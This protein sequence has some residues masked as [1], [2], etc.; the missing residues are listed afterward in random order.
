MTKSEKSGSEPSDFV[1]CSRFDYR[2][3]PA[4]RRLGEFRH[5]TASLYD[6]LAIGAEEDFRAEALGYRAD[7]LIFTRVAFSPT[8]FIRNEQHLD[9][10]GSGFLVLQHQYTGSELLLM[11]HGNIHIDAGNIYLRDWSFPFVSHASEMRLDSVVI[12]RHRLR[13]SVL[14]DAEHPVLSM[15]AVSPGGRMLA[16]IW[17]DL[18]SR[19]PGMPL[20]DAEVLCEAFLGFLDGLLGHGAQAKPNKTLRSMEQFLLVRLRQNV[21]VEDLCRHFHISRTQ[22]FRLFQPHGG[23]MAF[24]KR[25][26]LERCHAELLTADPSRTRVIDVAAS[27][28]FDDPSLFSRQFRSIFGQCPSAVLGKAHT[29]RLRP[30]ENKED[31]PLSPES[32]G[33][34]RK[35]LSRAARS[36]L[37]LNSGGQF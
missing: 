4:D 11:E 27:W 28:L 13:S 36:T 7:D 1:P 14:L 19:F 26:R 30:P 6:T 34:Y 35:W 20:G 3:Y 8:R 37:D 25:H 18:F 31:T 23:V 15:P 22:V 21:G 29:S 16:E 32:Y 33:E 17:S 24:L 9:D 12:P 5:M 10:A 2:N